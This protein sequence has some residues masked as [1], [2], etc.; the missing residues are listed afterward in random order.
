[1]QFNPGK[2]LLNGMAQM[3][4]VWL[5]VGLVL[6]GRLVFY[7]MELLAGLQRVPNLG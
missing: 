5:I 3:W 6:I 7:L 1:M 4:Y 2:A